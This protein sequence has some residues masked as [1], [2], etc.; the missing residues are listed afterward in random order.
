MDKNQAMA[1]LC[2]ARS[3]ILSTK[4]LAD[5]TLNV[6][7]AIRSYW[8][9]IPGKDSPADLT[10]GLLDAIQ[11]GYSQAWRDG[12]AECGIKPNDYTEAER[13]ELQKRIN[14][15]FPY[16]TAI[17]NRIVPKSQGGL[18]RDAFKEISL[19]LSRYGE[20]QNAARA[21]A[22]KDAPLEWVLG[23]AEHCESCLKLAGKVKRASWWQQSGIL[24]RRPGAWY[25]ECQGYNCKCSLV[26]TASPLTRG[27]MPN[28]P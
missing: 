20:V 18:L 16:V 6:R 27:R 14:D 17:A 2:R 7:Y 23:V 11:R 4:S 28:L 24:P 10:M 25:L 5:Y 9:G 13:Q 26:R 15:Q 12:S 8:K 3:A 22:C 21:M 19:L 1:A